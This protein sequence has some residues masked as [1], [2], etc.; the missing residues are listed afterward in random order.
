M[1]PTFQQTSV[2]IYDTNFS[3]HS[4]F[5]IVYKIY[6]KVCRN[7]IYILYTFCTHFVYISCILLVQSLYP[8]CT[9]NFQVVVFHGNYLY[10]WDLANFIAYIRR[11]YWRAPPF[12]DSV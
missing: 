7:V 11:L 4:Y 3:C 5:N 8:K 2:Y 9:Q 12:S 6:I 10:S 1:Y